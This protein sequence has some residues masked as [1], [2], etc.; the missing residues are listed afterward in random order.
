MEALARR[1]AHDRGRRARRGR[2][3]PRG[4]RARHRDRFEY[5]RVEQGFTTRDGGWDREG[6][7]D[8]H[9]D[10]ASAEDTAAEN[11]SHTDD[12]ARGP[13]RPMRPPSFA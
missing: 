3:R 11:G 9:D 4:G 2:P 13:G 1:R 8:V 10:I 7:M 6:I 5:G 12:S